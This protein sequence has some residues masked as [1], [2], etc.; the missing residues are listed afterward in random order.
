MRPSVRTEESLKRFDYTK[1]PFTHASIATYDWGEDVVGSVVFNQHTTLDRVRQILVT[2]E[3]ERLHTY[4]NIALKHR[5]ESHVFAIFSILLDRPDPDL[6]GLQVC[7]EAYP[8]L[9]YCMLKRFIPEEPVPLPEQVS[10]L[11]PAVVLGVIRSANEMGIA[12]LAAL[13]RLAPTIDQLDL[14]I[15]VDIIWSAALCIRSSKL[16][17]EVLLVLHDSRLESRKRSP[18]LDHAH[19]HALGIVFDRAEEAADTCACDDSGKPRRQTTAPARAK[20]VPPK[21]AEED[22]TAQNPDTA[23]T[24]VVA[25]TRVDLP[26]PIRIHDHVRLQVASVAPPSTLPPAVIDAIVLRSG[27]GELHLGVKQP[28]PPEWHEVDWNIFNAGGTATSAAMLAAVL[29]LAQ[30]GY[31]CCRVNHIISG[32][33]PVASGA[34]S[35]EGELASGGLGVE[36]SVVQA[37]TAVEDVDTTLND[38]QRMAVRLAV[39]SRLCLIW[40]PPGE[41]AAHIVDKKP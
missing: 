29:K 20:L 9:V 7:M 41:N 36:N 14:K 21:A 26:A 12:A 13:E 1:Q 30:K 27:R 22:D 18:A 33:D 38:S 24:V 15:Y 23:T 3:D 5:V 35:E 4:F 17:Q 16:V 32:L 2:L 37:D 40:G 10:L 11:A 31:E 19:K 8:S 28:L 34:I 39:S 25:H 6:G